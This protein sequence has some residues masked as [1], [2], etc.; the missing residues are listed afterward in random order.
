MPKVSARFTAYPVT[1]TLDG[2][3]AGTVVFQATGQNLIITNIYGSVATQTLQAKAT[4]SKGQVGAQ[5]S[6]VNSNSGSTGFNANGTI[7]LLDGET[8]YVAWTGGDAGATATATF[9]GVVAPFDDARK[10]VGVFSISDPIAAGDGSLIYPGLQSVDYVAGLAGWRIARNGDV[11]FNRG[12]FRGTLT[13]RNS[14][15]GAGV[16]I[17]PTTGFI[18][19][20]PDNAGGTFSAGGI[21]YSATGGGPSVN[22]FTT[23]WAPPLGTGAA[24]GLGNPNA[25]ISMFTHGADGSPSLVQL[26]AEQVTATNLFIRGV[27]QGYGFATEDSYPGNTA[28]FGAEDEAFNLS[29]ATSVLPNRLYR[30]DFDGRINQ[31]TAGT[32][33]QIR[34]RQNSI[35]GAVIGTPGRV[36]VNGNVEY[37]CPPPFYF[38]TGAS[39]ATS[40]LI[41]TIT[42]SAGTVAWQGPRGASLWDVGQ[43]SY[44]PNVPLI[45]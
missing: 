16:V 10:V 17:S 40:N 33:P 11:E 14:T 3:G 13:I 9:T 38:R 8:I 35:L 15:T 32:G 27:D 18:E 20:Y 31:N 30:L 6:L 12:T 44:R 28:A 26:T 19:M 1:V 43:A 36:P 23:S 42:P 24:A 2:T 37:V 22:R 7:S 41:V 25:Q 4:V 21:R 5:W 34:I 39:V 29:I 45:P